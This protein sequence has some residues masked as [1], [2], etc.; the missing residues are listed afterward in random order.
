MSHR[1]W[2][3][4]KD[5]DKDLE[6]ELRNYIC[7]VEKR[8]KIVSTAIINVLMRNGIYTY[9]DLK[10]AIE[11]SKK[12]VWYQE[13]KNCGRDRAIILE[14][15][16]RYKEGETR[17]IEDEEIKELKAQIRELQAQLREK[18]KK[19]VNFGDAWSGIQRYS[20]TRPDEY[21]IA[22]SKEGVEYDQ[23]NTKTSVKIVVS[24]SKERAIVRLGSLI[25]DLKGLYD[26]L[27]EEENNNG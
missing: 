7:K 24:N 8:E 5:M 1:K 12:K 23:K 3:G 2:I 13:I 6:T 14:N 20:T 4:G 17:V 22:I 26:K 21:Y 9:E 15:F 11:H 27:T 25:F 10:D 16:C 18:Q 19:T